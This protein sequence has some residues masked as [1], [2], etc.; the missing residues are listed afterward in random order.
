VVNG[1]LFQGGRLKQSKRAAV[2]QWSRLSG[3]RAPI[4][5]AFGDWS[6]PRSPRRRW[7]RW[8]LAESVAAYEDRCGSRMSVPV[9]LSS[10][11]EVIDSRG[12]VSAENALAHGAMSWA[13]RLVGTRRSR[14][15]EAR[16]FDE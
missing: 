2:A 12:T 6:P 14:R 11:F 13:H 5:N 1:S 7:T 15:M 3:L 16:R 8:R 10:Y 9:G 4:T